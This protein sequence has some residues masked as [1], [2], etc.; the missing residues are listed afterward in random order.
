MRVPVLSTQ[1][2]ST[3]ASASVALICCTSVFIR[4]SLTAA[5]ASVTLINSTRPSGIRVMRPAVAVCAASVKAM[6]RMPRA[7]SRTIASG[8]IT[9]V[10]A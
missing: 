2:V 6:S 9:I 7:S 10:V 4:A 8:T 1:M 5:T 3:A